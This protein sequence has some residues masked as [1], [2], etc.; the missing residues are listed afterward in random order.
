MPSIQKEEI[1]HTSKELVVLNLVISGMPSIL[2]R[3]NYEQTR[4]KVL[5]LVISGMPSILLWIT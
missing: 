3:Y 5:N 4:I 2:R 1:D